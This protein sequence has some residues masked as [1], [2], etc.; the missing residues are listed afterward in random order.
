MVKNETRQSPNSILV[1][2][3]IWLGLGLFGLIFDPD[4]KMIIISQFVF[5]A[6][7]V[8]YFIWKKIKQ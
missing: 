1:F 4:K 2:G 5:G 8:L 7:M 6:A 3:L